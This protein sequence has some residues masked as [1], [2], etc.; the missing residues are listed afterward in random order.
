[1]LTLCTEIEKDAMWTVKRESEIGCVVRLVCVAIS[2]HDFDELS[3]LCATAQR[4]SSYLKI[5]EVQD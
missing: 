3:S 4:K 2:N 5:V 1:M